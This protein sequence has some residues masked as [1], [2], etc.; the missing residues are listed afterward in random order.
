MI[1]HRP[2]V[3]SVAD[4]LLVLEH[5]R[6]TQFGPRTEVV[7]A[8]NGGTFRPQVVHNRASAEGRDE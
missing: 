6:I 8:I 1:A 4:K 7:S 5:G 3:M 2:S